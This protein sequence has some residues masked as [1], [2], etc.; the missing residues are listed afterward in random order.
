[1]LASM[2][3]SQ[4]AKHQ[5]KRVYPGTRPESTLGVLVVSIG[6]TTPIGAPVMG[7]LAEQFGTRATFALAG[8]CTAI[9]AVIAYVFMRRTVVV[10][11]EPHHS[12]L[13]RAR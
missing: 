9:A 11:D 6:G 1:M 12:P 4:A 2:R 10:A 7:W 3:P 5:R 13:S 8:T